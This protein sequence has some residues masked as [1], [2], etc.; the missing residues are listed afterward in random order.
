MALFLGRGRF[1]GNMALT[2][3]VRKNHRKAACKA[4]L[5]LNL[6]IAKM[7]LSLTRQ[8]RGR[9][10]RAVSLGKLSR[11]GYYTNTQ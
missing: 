3:P 11:Y 10:E 7:G 6:G 8:A 1:R 9:R 5:P 2:P 4:I